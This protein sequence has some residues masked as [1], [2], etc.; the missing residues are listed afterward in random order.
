MSINLRE[1]AEAD[2]AISLESDFALPV[3]LISPDGVHDDNLN[4]QVLYDQI[5]QAETGEEII[6]NNP[7]VSLRMSSLK[8]VP[9]PNETWI[10]QIPATPNRAAAKVDYVLDTARA[11]E[12]SSSIGFIR[13]YLIKA[14]QA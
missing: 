5:R 7:S 14:V 3:N 1:Q 9:A 6:V 13:L 2:L 8:R 11:P 12:K 10:V 4:G